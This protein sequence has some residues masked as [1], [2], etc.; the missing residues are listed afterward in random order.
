M[1]GVVVFL[2]LLAL[3]SALTANFGESVSLTSGVATHID[4][5]LSLASLDVTANGNCQIIVS[6]IISVGVEFPSNITSFSFA[7]SAALGFNITVIPN[8]VTISANF[9]TMPL[10]AISYGLISG[11]L[12]AGCLRF[13]ASAQW[14]DQVDIDSVNIAKQ[15]SVSL[16]QPGFYYFV[17][18]N[19]HSPVPSLYNSAKKLVAN[20]LQQYVYP[21][22]FSLSVTAEGN[23]SVTVVFTS[24]NPAP[25]SPSQSNYTAYGAFWTITAEDENHVQASLSHHYNRT[26]VAAQGI[27][28]EILMFIAYFNT[29]TNLWTQIRSGGQ[30]DTQTQVVTQTSNHFSSWG[31]MAQNSAPVCGDCG[32]GSTGTG[33]SSDATSMVPI[34]GLLCL[35]VAIF[36]L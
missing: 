13:D 15:I 1:K 28:N 14:Y 25:N 11:S 7:A 10:T 4:F 19:V 35:I 26:V 31:T 36:V 24:T 18:L 9:T 5:G 20:V 8:S 33:S 23:N 12:Q 21:F 2:A 34:F 17:L 16:P 30:V 3:S 6:E 32:T 29:S 22:G 27:T